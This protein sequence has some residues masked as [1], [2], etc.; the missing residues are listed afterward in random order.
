M[1]D[2]ELV[3]NFELIINFDRI[4]KFGNVCCRGLFNIYGFKANS[5]IGGKNTLKGIPVFRYSRN[6]EFS[7]GVRPAKNDFECV[8]MEVSDAVFW[9]ALIFFPDGHEARKSVL[10]VFAVCHFWE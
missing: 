5:A 9:L 4:L 6:C 3:I 2:F 10:F 7:L 8:W 1:I